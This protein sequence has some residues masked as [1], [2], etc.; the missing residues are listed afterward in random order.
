MQENRSCHDK[1][2]LWRWT[3]KPEKTLFPALFMSSLLSRKICLPLS[4]IAHLW[5]EVLPKRTDFSALKSLYYSSRWTFLKQ[6][7]QRFLSLRLNKSKAKTFSTPG[8]SAAPKSDCL[9]PASSLSSL[10]TVQPETEAAAG[11]GAKALPSTCQLW[12]CS[13][14]PESPGQAIF[15]L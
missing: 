2:G 10:T 4:N 13:A 9:P 7:F 8:K 14:P 5:Q 12:G 11:S 3:S 1:F 15:F 6:F